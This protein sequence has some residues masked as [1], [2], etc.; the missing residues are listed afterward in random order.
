MQSNDQ[1]H[2]EQQQQWIYDDQGMKSSHNVDLIV[3]DHMQDKNSL[4][5]NSDPYVQNK[6]AGDFN[7]P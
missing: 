4:K 1:V 2:L 3:R 7:V 5:Q 6:L